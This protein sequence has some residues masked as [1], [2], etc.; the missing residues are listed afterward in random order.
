[1][2]LSRYRVNGCDK[3]YGDTLRIMLYRL[4]ANP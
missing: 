3:S 4:T 1:M 2:N